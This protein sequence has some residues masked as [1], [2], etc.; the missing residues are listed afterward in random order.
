MKLP[1]RIKVT[2]TIDSRPLD[3]V[4]I[5]VLIVTTFKNNF[6]LLFGPTNE[7][8]ELVITGADMIK[9][10]LR[11]QEM[12]IMDYRDPEVHFGGDLVISIFGRSQLKS[13]IENYAVFKDIME[14]PPE[15]LNQLQRAHEILENLAGKKIFLN[16]A[17]EDGGNVLART[18]TD[19]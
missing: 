13:A 17:I 6:S 1:E 12:Y 8:G 9:E 5:L 10:A 16:V 2:A 14:Y 3:G 15:Y 11:A 18:E 19:Y 4:L 7:H